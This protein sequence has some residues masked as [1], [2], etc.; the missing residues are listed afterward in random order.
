MTKVKLRGYERGNYDP[1]RHFL[2]RLTW[3]VVNHLVFRSS[4]VTSY[5][6]KAK[7][8][9]LFGARVGRGVVVKPLVSIK[10]PWLLV[11]GDYSWIG[12][13]VWIDNLMKVTL[14]ANVCISQGSMILTGNHNYGSRSFD[15]ITEEV[16]LEEGVWI[17]AKCVVCPG[18]TCKSHSVLT[19]GSIATRDLES[20]MVYQGNP[21]KKVR[22]RIIN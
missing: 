5:E 14:G 11:I 16:Y 1:R 21:A 19:V 18:V 12:E 3:Y 22:E 9:R 20:Y 6:L 10:Y 17:G 15:L 2:I 4:I 7:I 13:G 8:L